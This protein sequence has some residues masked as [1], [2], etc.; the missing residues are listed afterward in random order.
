MLRCLLLPHFILI[1]LKSSSE[2]GTHN[3]HVGK[4]ENWVS[5]EAGNAG[6]GSKARKQREEYEG[7]WKMKLYGTVIWLYWS[8]S[9]ILYSINEI[10]PCFDVISYFLFGIIATTT[11]PLLECRRSCKI[12]FLFIAKNAL[13]EF[14]IFHVLL[15]ILIIVINFL[16]Y[17]SRT[18]LESK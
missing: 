14:L 10:F 17:C 11:S 1:E 7:W 2:H 12:Y 9:H 8:Q 3:L 15:F 5:G 4:K 16:F 6:I 13:N 18:S